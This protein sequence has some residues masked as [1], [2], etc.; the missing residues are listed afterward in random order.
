[1]ST[2]AVKGWC[3]GALRPMASGDGLVVRVRPW[4]GRLAPAQ[5]AGLAELSARFGN[6]LIDLTRR[7]NLQIRGVSAE[8]WPA[9][10]DGLRA[11]DLLDPDAAT[12]SRRNVILDPE[13]PVGGPAWQLAGAV[14]AALA[15]LP[16]PAKFGAAIGLAGQAVDLTVLPQGRLWALHA[17]GATRHALLPAEEIPR[18]IRTL[19]TWFLAQGRAPQGRGRMQALLARTLAPDWLDRP[20]AA[21]EAPPPLI[22][23]AANGWAVALP[24]G[25]LEAAQLSALATRPLRLTSWRGLLVE[26]A[27]A[28]PEIPGLILDPTDPLLRIHAC[29]G[30]PACPQALGDARALA[31]ALAPTLPA[32]ETLHVSGC[33]KGCAHDRPAH[34]TLTAT[35]QGW[36]EILNGR[37]GDPPRRILPR[38]D[39]EGPRHAPSL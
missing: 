14:V 25:L 39:R 23:R 5:A 16:L 18:A 9:L 15:P 29:T 1:M 21:H 20:G 35:R 32:G 10:L 33:A 37:A 31:R 22:G 12:E 17:T 30:A 6:G 4:L 26:G 3:P 36:A 8:G 27:T 24:F 13:A 19:A 2:P 34:R 38:S 28:P 7:A 11:L